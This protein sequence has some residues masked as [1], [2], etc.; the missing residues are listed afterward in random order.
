MASK[1]V[2]GG[3]LILDVYNGD[4]S[5]RR[6]GATRTTTRAGVVVETTTSIR[7]DRLGVDLAYDGDTTDS[8]DWQLFT[9][10]ELVD[11]AQRHDLECLLSC[12]DFDERRSI[13]PQSASMQLVFDS[14]RTARRRPATP[15]M[16]EGCVAGSGHAR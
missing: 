13:E 8:F 3:R 9:A 16:T 2:P 1:L 11:M 4:H 7:G 15:T 6:D 10:D 14:G 5:P 12:T